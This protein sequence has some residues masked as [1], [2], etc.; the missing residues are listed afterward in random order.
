MSIFSPFFIFLAKILGGT[1]L[2]N[3]ILLILNIL[4]IHF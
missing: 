2:F 1:Q 3:E 4:S